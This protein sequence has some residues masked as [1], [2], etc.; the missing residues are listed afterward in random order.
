MRFLKYSYALRSMKA[1][2]DIATQHGSGNRRLM[3]LPAIVSC[4]NRLTATLR[5][6][7][8]VNPVQRETAAGKLTDLGSSKRVLRS[9]NT[10]NLNLKSTHQPHPPT[11]LLILTSLLALIALFAFS[12]T[13]AMAEFGISRF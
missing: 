7:T 13:P 12:A 4:Y 10:T 3:S 5:P 9:Y 2:L 8:V 6:A 1:S 11:R